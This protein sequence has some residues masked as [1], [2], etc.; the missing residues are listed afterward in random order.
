MMLCP[1]ESDGEGT[2]IEVFT[3]R[4]SKLALSL[5]KAPI[6]GD[7]PPIPCHDIAGILK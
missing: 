4:L 1:L 7:A 2:L 3:P 6:P 5:A